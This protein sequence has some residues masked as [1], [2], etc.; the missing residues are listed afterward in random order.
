M[1]ASL[2]RRGGTPPSTTMS[3]GHL[4]C[5]GSAG[6]RADAVGDRD[7]AREREQRRGGRIAARRPRHRAR[8]RAART[9][10][11][12]RRPRP[13]RL[14]ARDDRR[15]LGR[16]AL[17]ERRRDVVGR[18]RLRRSSAAASPN[19]AAPLRRSARRAPPR[20]PEAAGRTS[21]ACRPTMRHRAAASHVR[22]ELE[23]QIRGRR[24][25]RQRADRHVVGAGRRELGHPIERD[26]AGD[27]DLRAAARSGARPR[28]SSSI[29]RLSSRMMSAPAASASSTCSRLCA[30]ISIGISGRARLHRAGP[31][32][33]TPPAEPDVVVLDQD[34][35]VQ[36]AAMVRAAAGADGVLLE[37]AQRRRRLA[38]VEDG[39]RGRRRHRRTGASA[40]RCRRAAAGN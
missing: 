39:D 14:R 23:A 15:P 9:T 32:P 18:A 12:P 21:R 8:R 16:A 36:A 19:G 31:L 1:P 26:A 27:L 33:S 5:T 38:R 4:I 34:A 17:G 29:D 25:V 24:R 22:L 11:R 35:V 37:R 40:S 2:R 6:R 10:S 7:A 30:S 20:G 13:A 28:G 3:F